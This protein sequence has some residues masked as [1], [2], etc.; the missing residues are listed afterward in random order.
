MMG[1]MTTPRWRRLVTMTLIVVL[2]LTLAAPARA[3]AMEV[4]TILAIASVAVVVVILV[5]FLVV[6]NVKGDKM[7]AETPVMVACV[8]SDAAP[9]ACWPVKSVQEAMALVP[10]A[11]VM[12]EQAP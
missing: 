11:P 4:F 6:A 3:E 7:R 5:V 8:E 10:G 12:I 2:A 9:R 1:A